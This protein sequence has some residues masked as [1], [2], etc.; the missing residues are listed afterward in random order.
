MEYPTNL[1]RMNKQAPTVVE[2]RGRKPL[3][4]SKQRTRTSFTL[5]PRNVKSAFASAEKIGVPASR[6]VDFAI[7]TLL[8]SV[9]DPKVCEQIRKY[10]STG[11]K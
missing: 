11:K 3:P 7:E 8:E 9:D 6:L 5:S 2:T 10:A 4:V 1:P